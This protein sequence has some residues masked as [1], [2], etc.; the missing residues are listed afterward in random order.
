[1][2]TFALVSLLAVGCSG[3]SEPTPVSSHRADGVMLAKATARTD[4]EPLKAEVADRHDSRPTPPNEIQ[5]S[6]EPRN[7]TESELARY[8]WL[9]ATKK[10]R[11]LEAVFA[12]PKGF[13]RVAA[14]TGS[15]AEFLRVDI[16]R[17]AKVVK[18]AKI[19]LQ[20]Y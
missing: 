8:A 5:T 16:A 20:A 1:M 6:K 2:R 10:V 13:K 3:A 17:W 14:P 4:Q 9:S 18:D 11:P 7:P 12:P 19:P 15:F